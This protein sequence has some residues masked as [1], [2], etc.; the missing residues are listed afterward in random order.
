MIQ[1]R[2]TEDSNVNHHKEVKMNVKEE[3]T[4]DCQ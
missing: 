4:G 1:S 2:E 3:K